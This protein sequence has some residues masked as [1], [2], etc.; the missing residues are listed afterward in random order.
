VIGRIVLLILL[1]V[2]AAFALLQRRRLT[3]VV[4]M[5]VFSLLLAAVYLLSHAPDVALTEAAIGAALITFVYVLAIRKTGRIVVVADEAPGLLYREG[6]RIVGLE[7][8]ILA[9]FSRHL[10]FDLVVEFR[11]REE[12]EPTLLRGEADI[13]AGGIVSE[14]DAR[15]FQTPPH[16]PTALFH[17]SPTGE[18]ETPPEIRPAK[19]FSGYFSDFLDR[20]RAGQGTAAI[21]DLA[22]FEQISRLTL[23]GY[24]V[25][26]LPGRYAYRFLVSRER[27]HLYE[28]L[29]SYMKSLKEEGTLEDFVRRYFS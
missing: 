23:S 16:L 3:A 2:V 21:L 5:G 11:P 29:V 18:K 1:P 15:F 26:R 27:E 19:I 24:E 8:E 25:T 20:T 9:G 22:R 10:G 17:L 12:V 6:E 4:G 28:Q 7:Q 14:G 13:G